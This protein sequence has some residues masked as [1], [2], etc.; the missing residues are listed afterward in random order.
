MRR[1]TIIIAVAIVFIL[2][3]AA[4]VAYFATTGEHEDPVKRETVT[5]PP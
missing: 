3:V 2:G 5:G 1:L 4:V